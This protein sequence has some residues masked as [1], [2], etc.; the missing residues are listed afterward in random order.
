V[1]NTMFSICKFLQDNLTVAPYNFDGEIKID[2]GGYID[3]SQTKPKIIVNDVNWNWK[4]EQYG[5]F[6]NRTIEPLYIEV[7]AGDRIQALRYVNWLIA[8]EFRGASNGLLLKAEVPLWRF[9][10]T[11][12]LQ[13]ETLIGKVIFSQRDL[14]SA[15]FV[16][17]LDVAELAYH[18]IIDF[19]DVEIIFSKE[20]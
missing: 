8:K 7:F 5:S 15:R 14:P 2:Y 16:P 13:P 12:V 9:S 10:E 11:G 6:E 3:R 18:Y 17:D 1:L 4:A 20:V 19:S